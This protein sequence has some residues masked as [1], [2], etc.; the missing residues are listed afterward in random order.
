MLSISGSSGS[1]IHLP[2]EHLPHEYEE[3]RFSS[4][5][6]SD[7][8]TVIEK[9]AVAKMNGSIGIT[10]RRS[11]SPTTRTQDTSRVQ[12]TP[13]AL[14]PRFISP[15]LSKPRASQMEVAKN[16]KNISLQRILPHPH[17]QVAQLLQLRLK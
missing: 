9:T 13:Y 4:D 2:H 1:A 15:K 16:W 11:P 6:E 17:P 14:A 5:Y 10:I 8:V 12:D 3:F 7:D